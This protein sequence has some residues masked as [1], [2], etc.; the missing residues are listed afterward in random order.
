M[1]DDHISYEEE[2]DYWL[3]KREEWENYFVSDKREINY[4]INEEER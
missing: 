1:L 4:G 2:R 3:M